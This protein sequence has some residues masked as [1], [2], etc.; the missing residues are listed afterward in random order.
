[1]NVCPALLLRRKPTT[2][3]SPGSSGKVCPVV[4]R[5][6]PF[7]SNHRALAGVTLVSLAATLP[8]AMGSAGRAAAGSL[9]QA[10]ARTNLLDALHTPDLLT[11][12]TGDPAGSDPRLAIDGRDDTAWTGRPG[13]TT[14]TWSADFDRPL[15]VGV[16]RA[17]FGASATS[18]VPTSFHWETRSAGPGAT[19]C[20]D[21]AAVSSR[22]IDSEPSGRAESGDDWTPIERTEQSAP[23]QPGMLAQPTHRSFFV[24]ADMCGLKLVVDRTNAGPPVLREVQAIESARDVLSAGTASDD[25]AYAGFPASDAIDGR[26]ATRW[27]GEPGRARWTLRVDLPERVTI[28]RIRLVLGFDATSVPRMGAGRSYAVSWMPQHYVLEVSADG[29]QFTPVAGDPLRSDGWVLPLRRRLVTLAEPRAVRAVRLVMSGATGA[30]GLPEIGAV[31]VV[32]EMAAYASSDPRPVLAA[33]WV[34]SVNANPSVETHLTPGGEL[35][36]D[37]YWAKFLQRRFALFL[38][39]MRK[40][41]RYDL[42]LGPHGEPLSAPFRDEAGEMLESIEGDDPLLDAQLLA[43]SSPPPIAVLSGS[44]DWDYAAQTG[45]DAAHPKRWHWDPLRS[46]RAS[47]MGQLGPAVRQRVAPFLGFCGGAQILALLESH[48]GDGASVDE[49]RRAIDLVLRRT[50]GRPIR[51]FAP[52]IDLERAWPGDPHPPRAQIQF[53]PDDSLFADIAGPS[54]RQSTQSFPESHSDAVRADAFLPGGPLQ[55]FQ[56]LASSPFCGPDVV[57]ASPRDSV[58]ANPNGPGWCDTVPEAFRS[59][60]PA[61]PILAT[62]FHSEQKDF[63]T[64]G[65][66]DPPE[67]VA[68]ARLF[69]AAAYEEMV[70]AYVKLAP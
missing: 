15:H 9:V 50:S 27:A 48:A 10:R 33:P 61:W 47:G 8:V 42:S 26:Y 24:D 30:S 65:P 70:D 49:D 67:S 59:R 37:A 44:D 29:K 12:Q 20:A 31:P 45:P 53:L 46:A 17:H 23:A 25:G 1:M 58:F 38:P 34:L 51:G 64:P 32:R 11:V 40:D 57:P 22:V 3:P 43:Q 28:D 2:S 52:P 41:D 62:Q 39:A 55:R 63:T 56:I 4:S 66:G 19:T 21:P 14:W 35:T 18:G 13:E 36:N 60:D 68:D 16:L 7:V 69:F 6:R 54:H 5:G